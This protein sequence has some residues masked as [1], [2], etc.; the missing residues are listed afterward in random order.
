MNNKEIELTI[1]ILI[2]ILE[3]MGVTVE[4]SRV[5]DS[6]GNNRERVTLTYGVEDDSND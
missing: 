5:C 6:Q 1:G 3:S 2:P 4:K